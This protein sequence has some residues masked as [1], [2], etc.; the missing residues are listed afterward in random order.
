LNTQI[1]PKRFVIINILREKIFSPHVGQWA[2]RGGLVRRTSNTTSDTGFP[3][4]KAEVLAN[5]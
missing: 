4:F 1:N 3:S 2:G 5:V